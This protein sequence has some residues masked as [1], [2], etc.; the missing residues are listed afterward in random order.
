[1]SD[2]QCST[3]LGKLVQCSLDIL[4]GLSVQSGGCFIEKDDAWI[5]E[6]RPGDGNT[7][8]LASR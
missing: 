7:L 2:Y 6:Y 8:F 5:L 3:T 1:M 4:F